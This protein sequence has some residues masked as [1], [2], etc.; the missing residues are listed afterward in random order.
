MAQLIVRNIEEEL[1]QELRIRAARNGRSAEEEH[2]RI[3]R[4]AL[5]SEGSE[6]SLKATLSVM[7]DV[8]DDQDFAR[9]HDL[10]RVIDL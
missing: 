8:G 9:N 7:P 2:R 3:L 5:R 4:R 10:G 1:V 6:S